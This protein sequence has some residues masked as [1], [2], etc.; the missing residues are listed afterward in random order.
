MTTSGAR[1]AITSHL[2]LLKNKVQ[3]LSN[4][5]GM[6]KWIMTQQHIAIVAT[7]LQIMSMVPR[8]SGELTQPRILWRLDVQLPSEREASNYGTWMLGSQEIQAMRRG[9]KALNVY[10]SHVIRLRPEGGYWCLDKRL[11]D[12]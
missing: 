1:S 8:S 12:T 6:F 5:A 7:Q 2:A 10:L 11:T 4:F 9:R 3:W